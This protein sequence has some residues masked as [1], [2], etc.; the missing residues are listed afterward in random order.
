[1]ASSGRSHPE[2][3]M[4]S[5]A[6]NPSFIHPEFKAAG[7]D[8]F[9][10]PYHA[11]FSPTV[12]VNVT[13]PLSGSAP[14]AQRNART[15]SRRNA[16]DIDS[17]RTKGFSLKG[18]RWFRAI[19]PSSHARRRDLELAPSE[20]PT[21]SSLPVPNGLTPTFNASA[22]EKTS[23]VLS[24][25]ISSTGIGLAVGG[26][27]NDQVPLSDDSI[28][29]KSTIQRAS[30]AS[31]ALPSVPVGTRNSPPSIPQDSSK[32][33]SLPGPDNSMRMASDAPT[34]GKPLPSVPLSA[35]TL[36]GQVSIQH[37]SHPSK[38]SQANLAGGCFSPPYNAQ[39]EDASELSSAED[40]DPRLFQS[41][42]LTTPQVYVRSMLKAGEGLACWRP[43]PVVPHCGPKGVVPGD[44]GTYSADGGFKK[45]FN[46]WEDENKIC[47][48]DL[49]GSDVFRLPSRVIAVDPEAIPQGF[50]ITEGVDSSE[51]Y[52]I[53]TQGSLPGL[54]RSNS[55]YEFRCWPDAQQGAIFVA[56]TSAERE[57]LLNYAGLRE[58]ILRHP[59]HIY[60]HAN[61]YG[62]SPTTSPSILLPD[63]SR[64]IAG[65]SLGSK[66]PCP[67]T[68]IP[69]VS[70]IGLIPT[71][72]YRSTPGRNGRPR[73]LDLEPSLRERVKRMPPPPPPP[74][75]PHAKVEL[76][77]E[78]SL[79]VPPHFHL[80]LRQLPRDG[81]QD[82]ELLRTS[83]QPGAPDLRRDSSKDDEISTTMA[84]PD[85]N[86]VRQ[87]NYVEIPNEEVR[88]WSFPDSPQ[89]DCHPSD[90]INRYLLDKTG[91]DFALCHDDEW[92]SA[93]AGSDDPTDF[94]NANLDKFEVDI[95]HGVAVWSRNEGTANSSALQEHQDSETSVRELLLPSLSLQAL[96]RH[97]P[98]SAIALW[99]NAE[100]HVHFTTIFR[101]LN[102]RAS[103]S[104][105]SSLP[106]HARIR[107][108]LILIFAGILLAFSTSIVE[109]TFPD[110]ERPFGGQ[111]RRVIHEGRRGPPVILS[112]ILAGTTILFAS[113]LSTI[114]RRSSAA[115]SMRQA[116]YLHTSMREPQSF[117]NSSLDLLYLDLR[118][119]LDSP[120]SPLLKP[121]TITPTPTT[122]TTTANS[123][124]PGTEG[125]DA[126]PVEKRKGPR[127][128]H[129]R[130]GS[131]T[132]EGRAPSDSG[133]RPP[134]QRNQPKD[135]E[136]PQKPRPPR[137]EKPK[138]PPVPGPSRR[139]KFRGKLTDAPNA[140]PEAATDAAPQQPSERYRTLPQGDD[141]TSTLIRSLSTPP[142]P[143]CPICFS[144]IHP[145]QPIWSCSPST[146]VVPS[147]EGGQVHYCWTSFHTK[148]IKAWAAK[149]VKEV[150]EAWAARGEHDRHGD[151]RCP[152]CQAKR[153]IVPSGY[154][155][156]CN[157]VPEPKL[158][159][160][161]TPHSCGKPCARSFRCGVSIKKNLSC[162]NVC[163][164]KLSCGKHSCTALCHEGE[165]EKC[166]VKEIVKCYC[167]KEEKEVECG[168]GVPKDCFVESEEPW[169]GRYTCD[170]K[171]E[172]LFDCGRHRCEKPCHPPSS[173][174]AP[175]PRSP[176]LVTHCPCG[177]ST[178]APP[179]TPYPSQYAFPARP[180]CEAPISTC[181][182]ICLKTHP[183]CSHPCESKCHAGPCPPCMIAVTRPCRCGASTRR[184][185]CHEFYEK[186]DNGDI[187]E[188]EILCDRPCTSL[189]ACG[190]HQCRRICCPLAS[191]ASA[192]K[193]GKKRA[194]A[195]NEPGIG[196]E[197]GGLHE[198]DLVCGKML[199]CGNHRCEE[200]DHRGPCPRCLR[201]SFEELFCPCG[202]TVLE[203]PIPCGTRIQCNYPCPRP[204]PPCGHPK[205]PHSCHD[206]SINCPPCPHLTSKRCACGKKEMPHVKCSLEK[207]KVS[208]GTVCGKLM[209]C[210]FHHCESLCHSG[211]CGTCTAPCGKSRKV[212]LPDHH[213]CTHPCHAPSACPETE[214]CESIVWITCSCGRIKQSVK[215]GKRV[216][217][218]AGH[219]VTPPICTNECNIAKRNA[220]LAEALGINPQDREKNS[221]A[222]YSEDIVAFGRANLKFVPIVEKAFADFVNSDK[223]N[224][225]LPHMPPEKR[226]FVQGLASVY[227]MDTRLIDQEPQRSVQLIKRIDT[228]IPSPTLS[229]YLASSVAPAPNFG[230]L[231][232]LRSL[233]T[234]A[235]SPV[236]RGGS[237]AASSSWGPS[238]T[239]RGWGA[240]G[241]TTPAKLPGH[242]TAVLGALP[243][244]VAAA[245][246][247]G[248]SSSVRPSSR[249]GS[250]APSRGSAASAPRAAKSKDD[251]DLAAAIAASLQTARAEGVQ[252][253]VVD[254]W[255]DDL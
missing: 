9:N 12:N 28:R 241:T 157:T 58:Y 228:R 22:T 17:R 112:S 92:L 34:H 135:G 196:E 173:K 219:Q 186:L 14:G 52:M 107:L 59:L 47:P 178:I 148:C 234:P 195:S 124:T 64:A 131:P 175:C 204:A 129:P 11:T 13:A 182:A 106:W 208:C 181:T 75:A 225:V 25:E 8:M 37:A 4:F 38:G 237:A 179:N 217:H 213:P 197:R 125:A 121:I 154:W 198:C 160:L 97:F 236:A 147:S 113:V 203:P 67:L 89:D 16:P 223:S 189:R 183:Q 246:T 176:S 26:P 221:G 7:R 138:D 218:P 174:P 170:Q 102:T 114:A 21:G 126:A 115:R 235:P 33:S 81:T 85:V 32:L 49:S 105:G 77:E 165:C 71:I 122:T 2:A 201:S 177:K 150:K 206:D 68:T 161:S 24:R 48:I 240:S 100:A 109:A 99:R 1:M 76:R 215:C 233:K 63:A 118:V 231:A 44:V 91:A 86:D 207:D 168:A 139:S 110:D 171:C 74:H 143:D 214:P 202:Q 3:N 130:V 163:G 39:P 15:T 51:N 184:I 62:E 242:G 244:S 57:E 56:T 151:W 194:Q 159:R 10:S 43:R 98:S 216:S 133:S 232:D 254:N 211:D 80:P 152:G 167:G 27:D 50:T 158:T 127:R 73:K 116:A 205:T 111:L 20:L 224:Q 70:P 252:E 250:S 144:S 253:A 156:F 238:T 226:A 54:I 94:V 162:G 222:V 136:K 101:L 134:R 220:K 96:D 46:I 166:E 72:H 18:F 251:E 146:P 5:G 187:V 210:G 212:C 169:V 103:T 45:I 40:L 209:S 145:A 172:R 119:E 141:L 60:L 137:N 42:H 247:A 31:K 245:T 83:R 191:L 82:G 153:E 249:A 95:R 35:E 69:C 123:Q 30:R 142:Y 66:A 55:S 29:T 140:A 188:K 65:P 255:E 104:R 78:A 200:R 230:R 132:T 185:P 248:P 180:N 6:L 87:H 149:S 229:A 36:G 164:R 90:V 79:Y 239:P 192:Q 120:R 193:K 117:E 23:K 53:T 227:R 88:V 199:S 61:R 41:S 108:A 155:C 19:L 190:R 93:S 84:M 128:P 243:P